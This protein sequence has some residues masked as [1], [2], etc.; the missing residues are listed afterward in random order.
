MIKLNISNWVM[1]KSMMKDFLTIKDFSDTLKR[2][3]AKPKDIS[4]LKCNKMNK[5]AIVYIRRQIDTS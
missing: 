1:W 5:Q 2:K 4:N 3:E